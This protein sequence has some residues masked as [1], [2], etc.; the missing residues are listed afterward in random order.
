[1]YQIEVQTSSKMWAGTDD[2][3]KIA[4]SGPL[5]GAKRDTGLMKLDGKG[6]DHE[7]GDLCKYEL[8]ALNLDNINLEGQR[9]S[10]IRDE[11]SSLFVKNVLF[12][13]KGRSKSLTLPRPCPSTILL[14]TTIAKK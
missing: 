10:F 9:H 7:R 8:P 2:N 5:G 3:V 6:N 14:S 4:L 13:K 11:S 12:R 1:M